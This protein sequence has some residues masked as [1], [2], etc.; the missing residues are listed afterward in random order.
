MREE[1]VVAGRETLGGTQAATAT[2]SPFDGGEEGRPAR[3][4]PTLA[5]LGTDI[6]VIEL[7]LTR[8]YVEDTPIRPWRRGCV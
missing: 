3:T 8:E 6:G 2:L 1:P 4:T 5:T 7:D